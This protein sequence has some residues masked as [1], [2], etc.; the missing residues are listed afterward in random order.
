M[1][2]QYGSFFDLVVSLI[3]HSCDANAHIFFE[4]RELRCRALRDIPAGAEVTVHYYPT[5]QYD[6]L[7]RRNTLKEYMFISCSC[8]LTFASF[9]QSRYLLTDLF[10]GNTCKDEMSEH[11]AAAVGR[12][13]HL[14]RLRKAQ[15][16]LQKLGDEAAKAFGSCR[17]VQSC[18]SFQDQIGNIIEQG[19]PN[20]SWPHHIEPL[21]TTYRA[22][23]AMYCDLRYVVGLEFILKGNL[24]LRDRSGPSWSVNLV[25]MVRLMFFLAQAADD[26]I[27]WT[28]A[29]KNM[30]LVQRANMRDVARGYLS[31]L[32]V[33]SKLT[34]GLDSAFARAVHDWANHAIDVAGDPEIHTEQFREQFRVSQERMLKWAKVKSDRALS[35]PSRER[36]VELRR[37]I[38]TVGTGKFPQIDWAQRAKAVVGCAKLGDV[39]EERV[40]K[41]AVT[42]ID[43]AIR[44][45]EAIN[46]S[47]AEE[48][49]TEEK[50]AQKAADHTD[51]QGPRS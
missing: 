11:V 34:F 1:I 9:P 41:V 19:Y 45:V 36:I 7:L 40:S 5:P 49:L 35:L 10:A 30:E 2:A 4:G 23:G 8:E 3:N 33:D 48:M 26:D 22:L 15:L 17:L 46:F 37:D 38:A 51:G 25:D 13:D 43:D 12:R 14:A 20:G 32:C 28:A 50:Q 24:Y 39:E 47:G 27:K 18:I 31:L 29:T 42:E 16:D 21:P 44:A 6:V